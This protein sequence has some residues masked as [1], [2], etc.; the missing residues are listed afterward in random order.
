M[1]PKN[2]ATEFKLD[3]SPTPQQPAIEIPGAVAAAGDDILGTM[4]DVQQ[5]AIDQHQQKQQDALDN[6]ERDDAGTPFDPAIHTGTK[7]K[8][9]TWRLRKGAKN[10][11]SVVA[12]SRTRSANGGPSAAVQSAPTVDVEKVAAAQAAG[13]MAASAVFMA[14]R[15]F[16]GEEWKPTPAEVEMQS[17]AWGAYFLAKD[18]TDMPPGMM[19]CIALGSYAGPRF[20]MPQTS[21]K[22]GR[23]KN[24]IALRIAKRKIK[25]ELRKRGLN[26]RVEIKD[27]VLLVDGKLPEEVLSK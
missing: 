11:G 10:P 23:V 9:G 26:M 16:G 19:L 21:A 12:Q 6:A 2:S 22:V 18:I 20:S 7:L 5:H 25:Q 24:W 4:P 15:G 13:A 1:P 27:G 17:A 3:D 14:C 8:N